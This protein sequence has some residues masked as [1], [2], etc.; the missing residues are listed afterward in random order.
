MRFLEIFRVFQR[1]SENFR[2]FLETVRETSLGHLFSLT[3]K[4]VP[5]AFPLF[6]LKNDALPPVFNNVLEIFRDFQR[7]LVIFREF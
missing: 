2:D 5:P 3:D 7:I 1:I 4:A 6:S